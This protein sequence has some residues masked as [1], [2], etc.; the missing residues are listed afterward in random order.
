MSVSRPSSSDA[1]KGRNL[2]RTGAGREAK[3]GLCWNKG[4]CSRKSWRGGLF[5]YFIFFPVLTFSFAL[6]LESV[7]CA[8][9]VSEVRRKMK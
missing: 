9:T 6:F 1:E 7:D 2:S 5:F 3:V 8:K 4:T